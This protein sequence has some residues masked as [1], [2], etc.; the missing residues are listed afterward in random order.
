MSALARPAVAASLLAALGLVVQPALGARSWLPA[1][2]L[3]S[4]TLALLLVL[5]LVARAFAA[6]PAERAPRALLAVGA[7]ALVVALGG[8]GARGRQGTL[9]LSP[10]QSRVHF[11]ET[12]RGGRPLGLRPLG[13]QIG[14]ARVSVGGEVLLALQSA[15][16]R[17]EQWLRPGGSVAFA[18]FR[19]ATPRLVPT[20]GASRLRVSISD[21][22]KADVADVVPGAPVAAGDVTLTLEQYFPDFAL[23][24]RQQ[25]F[26]RSLE[27]KNPAALLSVQRG[28]QSYRAFVLQSMPGVHRV[29]PLGLAFS[30]LEVEPEQSIE[31]SVHREPFAL[32]AL[33][34]AFLLGAGL[35]WALLAPRSEPWPG[36]TPDGLLVAGAALVGALLLADRGRVLAWSFS[37]PVPGG[38]A[39]LPGIGVL[40]AAALL[41]AVPG[42]LL[43]AA[44]RVA[45]AGGA[46]SC[47]RVLLW[48]AAA[49]GALGCGLGLVRAWALPTG[50]DWAAASALG[51]LGLAVGLVVLALRWPEERVGASPPVLAGVTLLLL[52]AAAASGVAGTESSG[53]YA[54]TGTASY[55]SAALVGLCALE[56][57]A[58]AGG[59][60]LGLALSV[61]T[62]L[63]RPL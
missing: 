37:V 51:G 4:T 63:L 9:A 6:A 61:L 20:G 12:G 48:L 33:G 47:A 55:A 56:P 39:V 30:L 60:A 49:A 57:T 21:G 17:S 32:V 18:G 1:H 15:Q 27:P 59:R 19:V 14:V 58:A 24:E 34:G 3:V 5:G 46:R 31:M 38:D 23:D 52:A 29:E 22:A 40:L 50:L 53:T 36:A 10:G 11:E 62:R 8:D 45:G 25:P 44:E 28:G 43:L 2:D 7:T 16:G 41:A 35:L 26:S 54:T 42:T 13:F